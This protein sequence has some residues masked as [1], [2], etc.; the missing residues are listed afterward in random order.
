MDINFSFGQ[1]LI[2]FSFQNQMI[3]GFRFNIL[4]NKF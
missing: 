4:E 3:Y 2:A 1:S